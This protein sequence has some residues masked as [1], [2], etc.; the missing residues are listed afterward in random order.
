MLQIRHLI[1]QATMIKV[2]D[3]LDQEEE[4]LG[5]VNIKETLINMINHKDIKKLEI[6]NQITNLICFFLK[7]TDKN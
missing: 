5:K 7:R 6:L 1:L 4:D 3:K 2:I